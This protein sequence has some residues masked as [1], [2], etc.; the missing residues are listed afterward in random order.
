[1]TIE[2]KQ[3]TQQPP[4]K[5][6]VPQ[7]ELDFHMMT[8]NSMWGNQEVSPELREKLSKKIKVNEDGSAQVSKSSL[9]GLLGFYTRDL[10]LGNLAS[11]N[12]EVYYC[13]YYLD[14]ANDM[15]QAD[16]I[17]PFLICL[18]RAATMLELSQSKGGFFRRLMNTLRMEN[19][20]GEMEPPKKQLFGKSNK[21]EGMI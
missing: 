10:R 4:Q 3:P 2:F 16:M 19:I 5:R 13:Q 17:E 21:K 20:S 7:S 18:S 14:L 1:M 15:L 9:W 8:T 6:P 11:W 12:G